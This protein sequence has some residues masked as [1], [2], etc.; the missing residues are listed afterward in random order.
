MT[1]PDEWPESRSAS[2]R[3]V[4]SEVAAFLRYLFQARAAR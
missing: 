4:L 2:P 1:H 3:T